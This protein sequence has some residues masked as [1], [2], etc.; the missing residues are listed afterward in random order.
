[1]EPQPTP[2]CYTIADVVSLVP[3]PRDDEESSQQSNPAKKVPFNS[4]FF[5]T[6]LKA[7]V[8]P[9]PLDIEFE[10][11]NA[12]L[13]F[14]SS[15]ICDE[16][17]RRFNS[18][19]LFVLSTK[20]G[21]NGRQIFL[22]DVVSFVF[23]WIF[24]D[25]GGI[26]K[27]TGTR[28]HTRSYFVKFPSKQIRDE[29]LRRSN[30][31][32]CNTAQDKEDTIFVRSLGENPQDI[33]HA[34]QRS[35]HVAPVVIKRADPR[36]SPPPGSP[37]TATPQ[38]MFRQHRN[39]PP[40]R[41]LSPPMA[42]ATFPQRGA[43]MSPPPIPP[44]PPAAFSR[45]VHSDPIASKEAFLKDC[46][47]KNPC[48]VVQGYPGSGKTTQ[49]PQYAA[50]V[51]PDSTV[52][53]AHPLGPFHHHFVHDIIKQSRSRHPEM[54]RD[55]DAIGFY[56]PTHP[57][58]TRI[59]FLTPADLL[60][61]AKD[62]PLLTGAPKAALAMN[63]VSDD[64]DD[65]DDDAESS[66]SDDTGSKARSVVSAVSSTRSRGSR[67]ARMR[68][69]PPPLRP[70]RVLIVDDAHLLTED[71]DLVLALGRRIA[72]QRP[73]FR[74][75]VV[76]P[77]PA[78]MPN[79]SPITHFLGCT[80][81]PISITGP[82]PHPEEVYMSDP[83][84]FAF[85]EAFLRRVLHQMLKSTTGD[86]LVFLPR[87][88]DADHLKRFLDNKERGFCFRTLNDRT[89]YATGVR[90]VLL[91][92]PTAASTRCLRRVGL[93]VDC[94]C[95]LLQRF[96]LKTRHSRPEFVPTSAQAARLRGM[97]TSTPKA[98]VVRLYARSSP[99]VPLVDEPEVA[100]CSPFRS[101]MLHRLLGLEFLIQPLPAI[102]HQLTT[103]GF[104]DDTDSAVTETGQLFLKISLSAKAVA[105]MTYLYTRVCSD[106]AT[107][108]RLAAL[109]DA[110]RI[111][112]KKSA[113]DWDIASALAQR[114]RPFKSDLLF[115]DAVYQEWLATRRPGPDGK[116]ISCGKATTHSRG[117]PILVSELGLSVEALQRIRLS[118]R[119]AAEALRALP[120]V[121]VDRDLN[122][123]IADALSATHLGDMAELLVPELPHEGARLLLDGREDKAKIHSG[124]C[125]LQVL[126]QPGTPMS[127]FVV[128]LDYH[129]SKDG[130]LNITRVHPLP[131][132]CVPPVRA[133]TTL[134]MVEV[135][136]IPNVGEA[137]YG[138]FMKAFNDRK[139]KLTPFLVAIRDVGKAELRILVPQAERESVLALLQPVEAV[140]RHMHSPDRRFCF[141]VGNIQLDV[142]DGAESR[143]ITTGHQYR[144]RLRPRAPSNG[145]EAAEDDAVSTLLRQTKD[146]QAIFAQSGD[147]LIPQK[148][149]REL[150]MSLQR[151][152]Q[153]RVVNSDQWGRLVEVEWSLGDPNCERII[154]S[155]LTGN[156]PDL[157]EPRALFSTPRGVTPQ[158]I[159]NQYTFP[160]VSKAA[161]FIDSLGRMSL[162]PSA[163]L[164]LVEGLAEVYVHITPHGNLERTVQHLRAK[165]PRCQAT[166]TA[167]PPKVTFRGSPQECALAAKE[168]ASAVD[169]IEIPFRPGNSSFYKELRPQA[170]Q[171]AVELGL[172]LEG[173]DEDSTWSV[174]GSGAQQGEFMKR[175]GDLYQSFTDRN[176]LVPLLPRQ[177]A[178]LRADTGLNRFRKL[179]SAVA[180]RGCVMDMIENG[181]AVSIG[182]P[183]DPAAVKEA[184][185]ALLG[186]LR[187]LGD[188]QEVRSRCDYCHGRSNAPSHFFSSCGHPYCEACL[189]HE[190]CGTVPIVC[191]TCRTPVA[192][193]DLVA[194][195]A[196]QDLLKRLLKDQL[197][198]S[199]SLHCRCPNSNCDGVV[200]KAKGWH[201]CP[202]CL[203]HVCGKCGVVA[204][205]SPVADAHRGR[206]C[207]DY[208]AYLD[209]LQAEEFERKRKE[210]EVRRQAMARMAE[211]QRRQEEERQRRA[212]VEKFKR[213]CTMARKQFFDRCFAEAQKWAGAEWERDVLGPYTIMPN[214][215]LNKLCPAAVRF[216]QMAGGELDV[217]KGF[218]AW[219][220][221][222][223]AAVGPI[224]WDGFDPKRR[225]GQVHGPGE[226]FSM[227]STVSK[228]YCRGGS[229]FVITFIL[230]CCSPT[231]VPGFCHVVPNPVDWSKSFCLPVAIVSTGG[232]K[233]ALAEGGYLPA[234]P[235][236][237]PDPDHIK[238]T[239]VT[240]QDRLPSPLAAPAP[241][242]AALQAAA[243][244]QWIEL[245]SVPFQWFWRGDRCPWEPYRDEHNCRIEQAYELYSWHGGPSEGDI[246]D[247]SRLCD[248]VMTTYFVRD[249]ALGPFGLPFWLVD[250]KE[251]AQHRKLEAERWRTRAV[252]REPK[253]ET[254]SSAVQWQYL[255][256]AGQ[257]QPMQSADQFFVSQ[258][259]DAYT[260][261]TGPG[262]GIQ[263]RV[264]GRPE[265]YELDLSRCVQRNLASNTSRP[266]RRVGCGIAG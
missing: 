205:S 62:D 245:P 79:T 152:P 110:G 251:M 113:Q 25:I 140:V 92:G 224:C 83:K 124:A 247:V 14:E 129:N 42:T 72:S 183:T 104:L 259:F 170:R 242:Q 209:R 24:A 236:P 46:I 239:F 257:W 158:R 51:F 63:E 22:K 75:V 55:P 39:P 87:D 100:L 136:R 265:V 70:V 47:R 254:P 201:E 213:D 34:I 32:E 26:V 67:P 56:S 108:A 211:E 117:C 237:N 38:P 6:I 240:D 177:Q 218:F 208:Q 230:S 185:R 82:H 137:F 225:A 115:D 60:R 243:P 132:D 149:A 184:E 49:L 145:E 214:P 12:F 114:K 160:S 58:F 202:S 191:P 90:Q 61:R 229:H 176:L 36:P 153:A 134:N 121:Q 1:M 59:M 233:P 148:D 126:P 147:I 210:D 85:S 175:M 199:A 21:T 93:V 33:I 91:C 248:D 150:G 71:I 28:G 172:D 261:G 101:V 178:V 171:W 130:T 23:G 98:R 228:S 19:Y 10:G 204:S 94:G 128:A 260:K 180:S 189:K 57:N 45:W 144:L 173:I 52:L 66:G 241:L 198:K 187:E 193:D 44:P 262:S 80:T 215:H 27:A 127:R 16:A 223:D 151:V 41:P 220:G 194:S 168:L 54:A 131:P 166:I 68:R 50:E 217:S 157:P 48:V 161:E 17:S 96:D 9:Q 154:T 219:H 133:R 15:G 111:N 155:Q 69:P 216:L 20:P 190:M 232:A 84:G 226:Y 35:L 53:V 65:D 64:D 102:G 252:K 207:A 7:V 143:L 266:I 2:R 221:T 255:D 139:S 103:W 250:F 234:C 146:Q 238:E 179:R 264:P 192:C 8:Y 13:T 165:R 258:A 203:L 43:A 246:G 106:R 109:L 78:P 122:Q 212:A 253:P 182:H 5:E 159:R 186:I 135:M 197:A 95:R 76:L 81:P 99:R 138:R 119:R 18:C 231:L 181:A 89:R 244:S 4:A 123:G 88:S 222:P 164:Q 29:V 125:M 142:N 3:H 162:P 77:E 118:T 235:L 249:P 37:A 105:F 97:L 40:E 196:W 195:Q 73:D 112:I 156:F 174:Y 163:S 31:F 169:P 74:M 120:P 86:A 141:G 188:S 116:C 107:C 206:S 11:K 167:S 30:P 263:M 256:A 227:K 200:A